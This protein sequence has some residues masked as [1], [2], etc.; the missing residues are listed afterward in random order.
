MLQQLVKEWNQY[1]KGKQKGKGKGK[2]KGKSKGTEKGKNKGRGS[3]GRR[4]AASRGS[5]A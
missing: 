4:Q 5:G 1:K 2:G 3:G